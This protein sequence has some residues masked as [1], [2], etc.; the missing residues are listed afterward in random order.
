MKEFFVKKCEEAFSPVPNWVQRL[1][2]ITMGAKLTYGRLLQCANDDGIAWPSQRFLA[3]ELGCSLRSVVN[4]ISELKKLELIEVSKVFVG[5]YPRTTYRFIVPNDESP[6][7]SAEESQHTSQETTTA[8]STKAASQIS[9]VPAS[10]QGLHNSSAACRPCSEASNT[11]LPPTQSLR[12]PYVSPALSYNDDKN[13]RLEKRKN[14]PPHIPPQTSET[15]PPCTASNT[16]LGEEDSLS[17][18]TFP[19]SPRNNT[20]PTEHPT[21]LADNRNERITRSSSAPSHA[22]EPSGFE[23]I[24]ELYPLKQGKLP[25]QTRWNRLLK[26]NLLPNLSEILAAIKA[27]IATDSRWKRGIVPNLERWL[28]ERR[29]TDVP[30]VDSSAQSREQGQSLKQALEMQAAK[31]LTTIREA[32]K[33]YAVPIDDPVSKEVI[34]SHGGLTALKRMPERNI[35]F[36]LSTFV[37]E[38]AALAMNKGMEAVHV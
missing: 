38:Y 3:R 34:E 30:F 9:S 8:P 23:A 25:A 10:E 12:T 35:P 27:H 37:K 32:I 6:V 4:Y 36:L 21:Q 33:G 7:P 29:W 18:P 28:R 2:T 5:E 31:Q 24:W 1:A 26:Q 11:C 14:N 17:S 16:A 22:A 20:I 15:K 19:Y 13:K